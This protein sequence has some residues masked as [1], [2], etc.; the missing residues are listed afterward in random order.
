[1]S[2]DLSELPGLSELPDLSL[3]DLSLPDLPD[4]SDLPGLLLPDLPDLS[5]LPP[6]LSLPDLSLPDLSHL[7][8]AEIDQLP[9]EQLAMI[10]NYQELIGLWVLRI[11]LLQAKADLLRLQM[12]LAY[13]N[14]APR[15][16][17]PAAPIPQSSGPS[18]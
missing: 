4:L 8:D 17:H 12:D 3:P 2:P 1:M 18:E 16:P 10:A 11:N 15:L 6:D 7:S 5:E 13:Q 9:L 14:S